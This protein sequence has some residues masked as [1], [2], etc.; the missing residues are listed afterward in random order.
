MYDTMYRNQDMHNLN[1][2]Y[3]ACRYTD[4]CFDSHDFQLLG[5]INGYPEPAQVEGMVY[6]AL[7]RPAAIVG[8]QTQASR[9]QVPTEDTPTSVASVLLNEHLS[10]ATAMQHKA[11]GSGGFSL[12]SSGLYS[13]QRRSM[14]SV[15]KPLAALKV[16]GDF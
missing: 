15:S 7:R 9:S 13:I 5:G 16:R 1:L 6:A 10:V 3:R 8:T 12:N 14:Q 2:L 11:D 4:S